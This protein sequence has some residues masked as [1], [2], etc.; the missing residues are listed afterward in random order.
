MPLQSS[1][2]I[3][4]RFLENLVRVVILED[5][6]AVARCAAEESIQALGL[7][8]NTAPTPHRAVVGLA[9]GGTPLGL[10][11]EWIER[12]QHG[13]I[14]FAHIASF[15]LDEYVGLSPD[16]PGSY[17]HYMQHHLFQNIDIDPSFTHLPKTDV[18]D[19]NASARDYEWLIETSGGI[20]LQ[21]LGI[22]TEG[23]IGFN[24]IGSSLSSGTRVKTLTQ[25]TRQDNARYFP[26]LEDVPTMAITM[27]LGTI[28]NAQSILLLATGGSKARAIRDA[29]EGPI[30]AMMPASIL[31]FHPD[32]T[33]I[34]DTEAASL[35]AH[36]EFYRESETNRQKLSQ[37]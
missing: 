5:A 22:G 17:H 37:Q 11:R 35:L 30:T 36:Q 19:L 3:S 31:Q 23:H 34:V 2:A 27:G 7:S 9:T 21:I 12:Y 10:Y 8:R 25:K 15:N 6:L 29:V 16:H 14:S 18:K 24:E 32:V 33:L 20:D 13:S 4:S 28:M 1:S 26:R